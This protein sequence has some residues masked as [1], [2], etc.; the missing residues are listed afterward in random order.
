MKH[1]LYKT[2]LFVSLFFIQKT[3]FAQLL[4][5]S[6]QK[7]VNSS[8]QQEVILNAMNVGNWMLMEGYMMNSASQAPDQHSWKKKLKTL[9]GE[10][11]TNEFYTAWLNNYVTQSDIN[12]IKE[13]GFNTLRI[14]LHYEYFVNLTAPDEWY[15]QGFQHLDR[16]LN[17]CKATGIYAI[18]DLHGT[19][20]GQSNN[21]ISDYDNTKPSLW[22]SNAN[23]TKTVKLWRKLSERYKNETII[24]G[25]DLINEP[26]WDIS[27]GVA[28]RQLYGRITDTIR[29]NND[30]HILFIEGN[31]YS[32]DYTG[33]TP[34]WD[35]NMVYVF[36]KYWSDNMQA[37]IKWVLDLR[38]QQNRP[39]WCG[40]HGENSNDHFTK[41]AELFKSFN[42]GSS[43]WTYKKLES[44]NSFVSADFPSGYND[45]LSYFAG[46]N[47]NF[48]AL[49]AKN[50]LTQLSENVKLENCTQ[51]TEVLRAVTKQVT[52]RNTEPFAT[53]TIPGKIYASHYDMGMNG[54]A[55][56]DQAWEDFHISTNVYTAWNEGWIYRNN[57]VDLEA[58][59]DELSNGYQV[60]WFN[61]HEWL[62]YTVNIEQTGTYTAEIRIANGSGTAGIVQIQNANGTEVLGSANVSLTNN[63]TSYTTL[64][65][66]VNIAQSG[67]QA[68]R[69]ANTAGSFNLVS[70]NFIYK[71]AQ[72]QQ[73]NYPV[74]RYQHTISLKG[75]NNL[76]VSIGGSGNLLVCNKVS[77][78][79]TEL[80]T[81]VDAGNNQFALKGGNGKYVTL[82]G[83]KLYCTGTAIES[84]Q[85]FNLYNLC[86][87]Y[88]I[89]GSNGKY[90]S[91]ENGATSGMTC[92]RTAPEGWE[93]F[94]WNLVSSTY[95]IPVSFLSLSSDTIH[96]EIDKSQQIYANIYPNDATNKEITWQSSHS[97]IATVNSQG[98]ITGKTAGTAT[99]TA[100]NTDSN[101]KASC[102][103][104]IHLTDI[105]PLAFAEKIKIYPNPVKNILYIEQKNLEAWKYSLY[106]VFGKE[107]LNSVF[108]ENIKNIDVSE[109]PA[110]VYF[111]KISNSENSK[112]EKIQII[113]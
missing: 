106:D 39:I 26:A 37:N 1:N 28:L 70:V 105:S 83:E 41:T 100:T 82:S 104:H 98:I 103:V 31:W 110:G 58:C 35:N 75:N 92:N 25:Y 4:T 86:G 76:Y 80:F 38:S 48:D 89:K 19:P 94:K 9:I 69:I 34:A 64:T 51:N 29:T 45:L 57:G 36:H 68:I 43:W 74:L 90:F 20:G 30:N 66:E 95:T 24:A 47:P 62:K 60:G 63:W 107:I 49:T 42:I 113:K 77:A 52:N 14:P 11:A 79:S 67:T 46:T 85:K 102:V 3:N 112:I 18:L 87:I 21:A 109:I 71:N 84:S 88:S 55:Y 65:C 108:T 56:N 23:K 78:N 22:E 91:S 32:N 40:E 8:N 16:I 17:A 111:L 73:A 53:Q 7:I 93:Y 99:I 101:K 61:Q 81:L 59:T 50:I 2:L 12:K 5:V 33:L 72:I 15:T 54:Y 27:G 13:M 96:L 6:G 44:I 10:T 97:S